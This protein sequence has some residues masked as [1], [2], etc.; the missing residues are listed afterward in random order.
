MQLHSFSHTTHLKYNM[1]VSYACMHMYKHMHMSYKHMSYKHM[2]YPCMQHK[3]YT[4]HTW[5][6]QSG[7]NL[8]WVLNGLE[9][10]SLQLQNTRINLFSTVLFGRGKNSSSYH[11]PLIQL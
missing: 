1:K 9:F 8:I 11:A 4:N 10:L 5:V 3:L 2:S 7:I 6:L